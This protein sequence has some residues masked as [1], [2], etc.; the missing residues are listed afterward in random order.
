MEVPAKPELRRAEPLC[1]HSGKSRKSRKSRTRSSRKKRSHK[2]E[3]LPS[4]KK[5]D[6]EQETAT[7]NPESSSRPKP[8]KARHLKDPWVKGSSF[9]SCWRFCATL[10]EPTPETKLSAPEDTQHSS[11]SIPLGYSPGDSQQ[12]P[13]SSNRVSDGNCSSTTE[14]PSLK[15]SST[16]TTDASSGRSKF[17][18][19]YFRSP[20][21]P[22]A[23]NSLNLKPQ[24]PNILYYVRVRLYVW[25]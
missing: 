11:D 25:Y 13:N 9:D 3:A 14:P 6:F 17:D 2:P 12:S 19:M 1:A 22:S 4:P 8:S 20:Y 18:K 16:T 5:L 23:L 7:D 24:N 21:S 10:G 15:R